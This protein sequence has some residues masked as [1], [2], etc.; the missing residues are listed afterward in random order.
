ME[1]EQSSLGGLEKGQ[2]NMRGASDRVVLHPPPHRLRSGA[3]LGVL[4]TLEVISLG[5]LE[6]VMTSWRGFATSAAWGRVVPRPAVAVSPGEDVS[7]PR[8]GQPSWDPGVHSGPRATHCAEADAGTG[9]C[10][11]RAPPQADL[12]VLVPAMSE[13]RERSQAWR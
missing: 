6:V 10:G 11:H 3:A 1:I 7:K 8:P 12:V 2:G 5:L 4:G 13:R 9:Q